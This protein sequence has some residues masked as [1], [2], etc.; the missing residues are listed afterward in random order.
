MPWIVAWWS[1]STTPMLASLARW[2]LAEDGESPSR[3]AS[4]FGVSGSECRRISSTIR[5]RVGL[6]KIF[7]A[8]S[9]RSVSTWSGSFGNVGFCSSDIRVASFHHN[10]YTI[11]IIVTSRGPP[12]FFRLHA[13]AAKARYVNSLPRDRKTYVERWRIFWYDKRAGVGPAR[14][15]KGAAVW[16]SWVQ[17]RFFR[18]VRS[19][20][21]TRKPAPFPCKIETTGSMPP[22]GCIA[23][24]LLAADHRVPCSADHR[25]VDAGLH[26]RQRLDR[27]TQRHCH[28]HQHPLHAGAAC[29]PDERGLQLP[30]RAGHDPHQLFG[31]LHHQQYG[32]F[33]RQHPRSADRAV[34]G[35]V[36][37]RCVQRGGK[38]LRHPDL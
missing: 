21:R 32:G 36:L 34:R 27:R 10:N 38:L 16:Y 31:C 9:P 33:W 2:C 15:A 22:H 6:I 37:N 28:L 24:P 18:A 25:A 17:G 1:S 20:K 14:I 26:F 23:G 5:I 4:A 29:H 7:I 30:W 11:T 19:E 35:A 8:A 12:P 13:G 3:S